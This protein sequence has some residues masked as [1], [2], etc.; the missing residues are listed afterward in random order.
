M[1]TRRLQQILIALLLMALVAG[2]IVFLP[3]SPTSLGGVDLLPYWSAAYLLAHGGNPYDRAQL[4][5]VYRM[6][7][8]NRE[9]SDPAWNPPWLMLLLTPLSLLPYALAARVWLLFN[10]G[11]LGLLP[12]LIWRSLAGA[13]RLKAP[14]WLPLLGLGWGASLVTIGIGQIVTIVL[15]GLVL[16]VVWLRAGHTGR[17]GAILLL[18]L[19]KPQL[20]Y[21]VVPLILLWA[22]VRRQWRVWWGIGA[23]MLISLA[24]VTVLFPD[25]PQAYLGLTGNYDFFRHLSA[26]IGGAAQAY[27]NMTALRYAGVLTLLLL[28]WL[29]RLCD[30]RDVWTGVN[31]ALLISLPLAP[32]GWSFDQIVLLPVIVQIVFWLR[33]PAYPHVQRLFDA[34]LLVAIYLGAIIMKVERVGDVVF[35]WVPLALGGLYAIAYRNRAGLQADRLVAYET[36][37]H[38]N[39]T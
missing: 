12:F 30:R 16:C 17:A 22:A 21:L 20:V 19:V 9:N 1:Q 35:V 10:F 15:L 13:A 27:L 24:G 4:I 11:V 25:W 26:T 33:E 29:V 6:V 8:V 28:P 14:L 23:T 39:D 37:E 3:V 31:T 32:Y 38:L 36:T 7:D 5:P 18:A 2:L 34:G